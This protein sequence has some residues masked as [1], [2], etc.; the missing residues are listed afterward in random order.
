[1]TNKT[2][3]HTKDGRV[4]NNAMIDDFVAEAER[5]YKLEDLATKPRGRGRPPLGQN[6]KKVGSVRL[7]P[8][9][10]D[11][12]AQRA[13]TDGVT[14]SEVVRRALRAYLKDAS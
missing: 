8:D 3:G 1:M 12:A 10:R 11:Q 7:D 2:Y 5:G 4:I 13:D 9:L 14:V 6:A